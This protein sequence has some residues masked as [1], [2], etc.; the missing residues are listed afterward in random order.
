MEARGSGAKAGPSARAGEAGE[1]GGYDIA[2]A[3]QAQV[4]A[5][6]ASLYASWR[7]V[8]GA[9]SDRIDA[10][11]EAANSSCDADLSS[12]VSQLSM[13][14]VEADRLDALRASR[15]GAYAELAALAD[16]VWAAPPIGRRALVLRTG[17]QALR[18]VRGG[19]E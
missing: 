3:V 17:Q 16:Q 12:D 2:A 6:L 10:A 7:S 18:A 11:T 19:G 8:N 5:A 13:P 14:K 1:A 15:P 4:Q 9:V